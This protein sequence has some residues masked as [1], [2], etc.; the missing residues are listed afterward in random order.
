MRNYYIASVFKPQSL[1]DEHDVLLLI[2]LQ[3]ILS[4]LWFRVYDLD[5]GLGGGGVAP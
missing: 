4:S 1:E 2:D 3:V 5:L